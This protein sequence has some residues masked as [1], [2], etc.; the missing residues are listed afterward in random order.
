MKQ[1]HVA[2]SQAVDMFVDVKAD[3]A[4]A[5]HWYQASHHPSAHS[6]ST[7]TPPTR[8]L[9]TQP[10]PSSVF[11]LLRRGTFILTTEPVMQPKSELEAELKKRGIDPDKFV[12]LKHG[13]TILVK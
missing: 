7:R 12:T 3:K 4:V 6:A 2:P 9:P 5:V 10:S 11:L 1:V 8:T 13:E